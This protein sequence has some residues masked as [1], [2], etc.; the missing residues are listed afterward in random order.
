VV[1]ACGGG[2]G[3]G[4]NPITVVAVRFETGPRVERETG[5]GRDGDPPKAAVGWATYSYK[6]P[7]HAR[8]VDETAGR[9]DGWVELS[10]GG[11]GSAAWDRQGNKE[12]TRRRRR[13]A[14]LAGKRQL[15]LS[16]MP[17][18]MVGSII[19]M[20][21]GVRSIQRQKEHVLICHR[22]PHS[23]SSMKFHV[24][25]VRKSQ[26]DFQ[27]VSTAIEIMRLT[28]CK[29]ILCEVTYIYTFLIVT[30]PTRDTANKHKCTSSVLLEIFAK[31]QS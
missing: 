4:R 19:G 5:T 8:L 20:G 21:N 3:R 25:D 28:V 24:G 15:W 9:T 10:E 26:M 30:S 7:K 27:T 16:Y 14:L 29:H 12:E 17:N 11:L 6:L 18:G 13:D 1:S 31:T 2:V 22:I 23:E